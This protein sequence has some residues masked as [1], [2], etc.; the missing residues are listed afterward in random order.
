MST[1]DT[2]ALDSEK[3]HEAE[4]QASESATP[5]AGAVENQ[6]LKTSEGEKPEGDGKVEDKPKAD[7]KS[8]PEG[9]PEAYELETPKGVDDIDKGVLSA[10]EA[11]AKELNLTNDGAQ[12][13]LDGVLPVMQDQATEAQAEMRKEWR[14]QIHA[15]EEIGG[16]AFKTAAAAGKRFV[17]EFGTD[18]F[19]EL[20]D[21]TG[22]GDHPEMLRVFAR[23]GRS[24]SPDSILT[25]G[26]PSEK[27]EDL[28]DP[29]VQTRRMYPDS[30]KK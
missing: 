4:D 10:F 6:Q 13:I 3:T 27:E 21:V 22:L 7:T 15:D 24:I 9:A 5:E 2:T 29:A 11:V 26:Q 12:Q 17:S 28:N 19:K 16:D 1:T 18:E 25:G 14:D 23:A 20:L 8:E 30:S